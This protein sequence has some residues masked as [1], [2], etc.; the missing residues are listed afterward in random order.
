MSIEDDAEDGPFLF[1]V[2]IPDLQLLSSL[3]I[4]PRQAK[5]RK[6]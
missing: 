6:L 5:R 1:V 3:Q 2:G 4:M